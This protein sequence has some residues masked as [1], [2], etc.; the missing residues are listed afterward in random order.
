[1]SLRRKL[2]RKAT[3]AKLDRDVNEAV[4][5]FR[6]ERL[7]EAESACA[8]ILGKYPRSGVALQVLGLIALRRRQF[9]RAISHLAAAS[10]LLPH[11]AEIHCNLGIA[12]REAGMSDASRKSLQQALRLKPGSY[13]GLYNLGIL[14]V[15]AGRLQD[16][17]HHLE[18]ALELKS[19]HMPLV[20]L[21]ADT[22]IRVRDFHRAVKTYEHYLAHRDIDIAAVLKETVEETPLPALTGAL[23]HIA[24]DDIQVLAQ[25]ANLYLRSGERAKAEIAAQ[26]LVRSDPGGIRGNLV[27]ATLERQNG[28]LNTAASRIEPFADTRRQDDDLAAALTELGRIYDLMGR[29]EKAFSTFA[30]ANRII[31]EL[32]ATKLISKTSMPSL[33]KHCREYCEMKSKGP[34]PPHPMPDTLPSPLFLVGFPR[35]GTTLT[36]HIIRSRFDTISSD[37]V[38]V[39]HEMTLKLPRLL[40]RPFRYPD[41]LDTL[42]ASEIQ[43][44]RSHYW[45]QVNDVLDFSIAEEKRFLDKLPLNILHLVFIEKIFPQAKIIVALRDPRDV[46]LS[47]FMQIF[48]LNDAIV[49]FLDIEDTARL[50]SQIMRFWL[51]YRGNSGINWHESRYEDI[52]SDPETATAKLVQFIGGPDDSMSLHGTTDHS[53]APNHVFST[54]SYFDVNQPIYG[55]AAGRWK[56]YEQQLSPVLPIL[57]EFLAEFGYRR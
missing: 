25:L 31:A 27:L 5:L 7:Q 26:I 3:P 47:N 44:L 37:E 11:A 18:A 19:T 46:C 40:N 33:V 51:A 55:R 4:Q 12:Y 6:S 39:L 43:Q 13:D 52:V 41:D 1:M 8:K 34:A 35:S 32:P 53:P 21:L 17:I 54:P 50:Y 45:E 14:E 16:G 20:R 15:Q 56:N 38:P 2:K 49:H 57:E 42:A 29:Y 30:K 36:E 24:G 48:R 9:D 10:S 22:C 28:D 23:P